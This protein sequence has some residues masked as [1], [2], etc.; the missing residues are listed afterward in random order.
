MDILREI[1]YTEK[2]GSGFDKIFTALLSKGK[3]LPRPQQT[4]NSIIL[5][6]EADVYSEKLAELSLLYKQA[7]KKDI[8]LEKLLVLNSIYTGQKLTFQQLE[9]SP[10]I[11]TY[12]LR[13]ILNELRDLEFIETTGKTSDVKYI[14]HK[15]KI[16]GIADEKQYLKQKQQD[17][18]RQKQ[19]ILK[20]LDEF[21]EIDNKTAREILNLTDGDIYKVSRMFKQLKEEEEIEISK[22]DKGI[23]Y[24]KRKKRI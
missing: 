22:N 15:S 14:I 2:A 20:Y 12:Q 1:S 5:R 17:I 21:E 16:V 8:D 11:N 4:D 9:Q 19:I 13:K 23:T 3:N 10:F 7:T 18:F 24:Y 6:I